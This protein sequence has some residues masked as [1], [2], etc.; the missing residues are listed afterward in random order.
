MTHITAASTHVG[1]RAASML[2]ALVFTLA[3]GPSTADGAKP[4]RGATY[5]G[6][7]GGKEYVELPVSR[8]GRRIFDIIGAGPAA[9][10]DGSVSLHVSSIDLRIGR[11]GRFRASYEAD[12]YL[13]AGAADGADENAARLSGDRA[14]ARSPWPD[15]PAPATRRSE[16]QAPL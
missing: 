12:A 4:V 8:D 9:C 10:E 14:Q 15:A 13:G 1:H 6:S 2:L 5:V 16:E 3:L 11:D 7:F